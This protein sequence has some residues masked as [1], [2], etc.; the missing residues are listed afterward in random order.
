MRLLTYLKFLGTDGT[1]RSLTK[2]AEV[3]GCSSGSVM[4]YVNDIVDIILLHKSDY[5]Q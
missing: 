2:I 4:E 1:D 5:L 3:I